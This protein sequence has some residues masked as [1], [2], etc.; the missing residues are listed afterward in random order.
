MKLLELYSMGVPIF[1]P[2]PGF[3]VDLEEASV[4]LGMFW[5]LGNH[6]KSKKV[7]KSLGP[8]VLF[9]LKPTLPKSQ[10]RTGMFDSISCGMHS[11]MNRPFSFTM[12]SPVR[13]PTV[14]YTIHPCAFASDEPDHFRCFLGFFSWVKVT[15]PEN[16]MNE[17]VLWCLC[18]SCVFMINTWLW[19]GL[20]HKTRWPC[21]FLTKQTRHLQ[22][23]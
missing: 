12:G 5:G 1:M 15:D 19:Y 20:I 14:W 2:A 6:G 8:L 17:C 10:S 11:R 4:N 7:E 21:V 23:R 18:V 22:P 16:G 3:E 9:F 13:L